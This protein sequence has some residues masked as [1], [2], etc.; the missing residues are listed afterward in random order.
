HGPEPVARAGEPGRGKAA[1]RTSVLRGKKEVTT[2]R[3]R[4]RAL[5][6][7]PRS[8]MTLRQRLLL[9]LT[10]SLVL[11]A[12]LAGAGILLLQLVS[13]RMG[14]ILHENYDSVVFMMSLNEALE[15]IDSSFNYAM[16]GDEAAAR[17]A[18][19]ANWKRYQDE[20]RR[21]QNNVT[22]EGE[23]ELVDRLVELTA[24]YRRAGDTF[25]TPGRPLEA[26]RADYLGR[27][28]EKGL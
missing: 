16:L 26:R 4:A 24:E 21:E 1:G 15:R 28:G 25:F 19:A 12:A 7:G 8:N 10:P 20:L 3:G 18:Y 17:A 6:R 5:I 22:L 9:T 2:P 11:L 27:A 14:E 13:D 23:Q